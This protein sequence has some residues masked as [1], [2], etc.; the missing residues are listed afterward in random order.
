MRRV[1]KVGV[2]DLK[3]NLSAYLRDVRKGTRILVTDRTEVTAELHEPGAV[4]EETEGENPILAEWIEKGIV[5]PAVAKKSPL[6][7]SPVRA[8]EGTALRLIHESREE[9]PR[10]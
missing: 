8:K 2:K 4:D 9:G 3:N 1:K 6:P 10:R 7:E 5:I